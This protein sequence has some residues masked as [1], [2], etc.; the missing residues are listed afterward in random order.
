MPAI[1]RHWA[2]LEELLLR[3]ASPPIRNAGT[4]GGNVA[5]GS[6][7][8]DT[9]PA[10]LALDA[11]LILQGGEEIGPGSE[12]SSLPAFSGGRE[13]PLDAYYLGYR[14]TARR[15]GELLTGIRIPLPG[16]HSRVQG[17]K[18]SKRFDQDISAV[19]GAFR[20][21]L[22]DGNVA[23]VR[24]AFGG[25]AAIPKRAARCEQVLGGQRWCE[26][27]VNKAC[28]ALADDFEPISDM[29]ASAAYRRTVAGNLLR[30]FFIE[31]SGEPVSR[32]YD[33]GRK[34]LA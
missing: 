1:V 30:R 2:G 3:F 8:G 31:T 33:Y 21:G 17:Y 32:V 14:Q 34:K 12:T 24:V 27:T 11:T 4:L 22:E 18:V 19:C 25:M 15:P 26:D 28:A 16:Q 10:L 13:L 29:R 20:V 23:D 6:P 9:M 7:I 5:N